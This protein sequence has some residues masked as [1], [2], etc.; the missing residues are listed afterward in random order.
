MV[1]FLRNAFA[2]PPSRLFL[3]HSFDSKRYGYTSHFE[4]RKPSRLHRFTP[5]WNALSS[6]RWLPNAALPPDVCACGGSFSHRSEPEWHFQRSRSTLA[7]H[8]GRSSAP[9]YIR[10]LSRAPRHSQA[11]TTFALITDHRDGRPSRDG[12]GRTCQAAA[13]QTVFRTLCLLNP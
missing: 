2:F 11:A 7:E 10:G 1:L 13:S 8:G 9:Y 6:K 5:R 12:V 4:L 3:E